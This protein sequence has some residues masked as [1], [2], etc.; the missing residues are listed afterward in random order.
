M[1][2]GRLLKEKDMLAMQ[3]QEAEGQLAAL[4]K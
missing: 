2:L 4:K 1:A 3:I